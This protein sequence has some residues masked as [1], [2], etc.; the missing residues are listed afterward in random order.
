METQL[1]RYQRLATALLVVA[2]LLYVIAIVLRGRFPA[3]EWLRAFSEAAMV[4]GAAD[5]FAVTALFRYPLGLKIPHTNLIL[6]KRAEL[7][8]N[9]GNFVVENFLT[10]QQLQSRFSELRLTHSAVAWL[11]KP[12]NATLATE[13]LALMLRRALA[14]LPDTTMQATIQHELQRF[15]SNADIATFIA[16]TLEDWL[17]EGKQQNLLDTIIQK[18]KVYLVE[19]EAFIFEKVKQ[20]SPWVFKLIGGDRKVASGFVEGINDLLHEIEINPD[21]AARKTVDTELQSWAQRLRNDANIR[22]TVQQFAQKTIESDDLR[23]QIDQIWTQTKNNLLTQLGSEQSD[24]RTYIANALQTLAQRLADDHEWQ[25]RVDGY[26]RTEIEQ[27]IP[28][29]QNAVNQ[30]IGKQVKEMDGKQLVNILEL[31]VGKDLQFVRM[32]GTLVGGLIGLL[33]YALTHFLTR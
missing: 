5:W 11:Q 25:Q 15:L 20:K 10:Y 24:L 8:D 1:R 3:L 28:T 6:A 9:L 17:M 12:D 14:D 26:I 32:N 27:Y 16:D 29:L 18:A 2:S 30:L 22:A 33:I 7:A 13:H 4:G 23:T 31:N 21:H 19:N